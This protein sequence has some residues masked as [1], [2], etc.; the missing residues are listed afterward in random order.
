[1]FTVEWEQFAA[2]AD[3]LDV[4]LSAAQIEQFMTYQELLLEWNARMNLTAVRE[5]AEIR[6]RHFLDSLSCARVMGDLN[7]RSLIDVGTG[8][9]FPGLPLKILFPQLKLTLVESVVKKTH[10]LQAVVDALSLSDVTIL[11]DRAELLGQSPQ[12]RRQYDWAV[13][14]AVAELRVLVEYLLPLCAVGGSM[15]AQKGEGVAAE[16]ANAQVAIPL[17]GGS[18]PELAQVTLPDRDQP[19]YFVTVKKIGET[20][21]KY[22]RRVGMPAKRPL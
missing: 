3:E 12:H 20:P 4:S 7:G 5:P 18:E 21:Q 11:T 6:L 16:I 14:R 17:L 15:L 2:W 9:G 8:A 22:P 19:H 10:F 13:A 1:M